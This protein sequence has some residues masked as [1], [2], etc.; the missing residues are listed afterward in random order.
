[1]IAVCFDKDCFS[2]DFGLCFNAV[3][4]KGDCLAGDLE[5]C[6]KAVCFSGERFK[7]DFR[8][9]FNA[10]CFTGDRFA[11]DCGGCFNAI[12]SDGVRFNEPLVAGAS[13]EIVSLDGVCFNGVRLDGVRFETSLS[14]EGAVLEVLDALTF[15][16]EGEELFKD[17]KLAVF[18]NLGE[19]LRVLE[20]TDLGIDGLRLKGFDE[21][22]LGLR[23]FTQDAGTTI[24][25]PTFCEKLLLADLVDS[26][27][28]VRFEAAGLLTDG[29]AIFLESVFLGAVGFD[30]TFEETIE[31][32]V[33]FF[34]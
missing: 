24:G 23:L 9:C 8:L 29:L 3:C 16:L 6:F 13:F 2:G 14:M 27:K 22:S 17:A 28:E 33:V 20:D 10:V 11:G 5:L 32:T 12:R 1:M 18:R 26:F 15:S 4:F 7:G 19:L 25:F 31:D 30:G 21:V 34:F